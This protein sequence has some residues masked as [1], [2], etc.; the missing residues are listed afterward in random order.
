MHLWTADT[1]ASICA[2]CM[3]VGCR[4]PL[5]SLTNNPDQFASELHTELLNT[6]RFRSIDSSELEALCATF[7]DD[8]ATHPPPPPPPPNAANSS[9]KVADTSTK[10]E[11]ARSTTSTSPWVC[12]SCRVNNFASRDKCFR[13]GGCKPFEGGGGQTAEETTEQHTGAV[14][15]TDTDPC[16]VSESQQDSNVQTEAP[17]QR[18]IRVT[19]PH[20]FSCLVAY[21]IRSQIQAHLHAILRGT[22]KKGA[23]SKQKHPALPILAGGPVDRTTLQQQGQQRQNQLNLKPPLMTVRTNFIP[24]VVARHLHWFAQQRSSATVLIGFVAH[25]CIARRLFV[26][27]CGPTA[28]RLPERTNRTGARK[29]L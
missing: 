9:A 7:E 27:C 28:M 11:Q 15:M 16:T 21:E 1:I 25:T 22:T 10:S 13:C 23:P 18:R 8:A 20:N 14:D 26:L 29:Y 6:A 17:K 24:A 19:P 4:V 3:C 12:P 2:A 5:P